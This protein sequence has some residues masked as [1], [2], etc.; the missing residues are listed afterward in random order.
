[1]LALSAYANARML[2]VQQRHNRHLRT[3]DRMRTLRPHHE[4]VRHRAD[5][6]PGMGVEQ[7]T[8]YVSPLLPSGC[9]IVG[10]GDV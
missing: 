3:S 6:A 4:I 9:C 8:L 5:T 7:E 10:F 1:M 2:G